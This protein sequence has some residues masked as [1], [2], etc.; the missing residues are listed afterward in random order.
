MTKPENKAPRESFVIVDNGEEPCL[1]YLNS[2]L[3]DIE[4]DCGAH[5]KSHFAVVRKSDFDDLQ[6]EIAKMLACPSCG[7]EYTYGV[8]TYDAKLQSQLDEKT[9]EVERL[10]CEPPACQTYEVECEALGRLCEQLEIDCS[11]C[12]D[13]QDLIRL[14]KGDFDNLRAELAEKTAEADRL[15][16]ALE[17]ENNKARERFLEAE[18]MR[19]RADVH[20]AE[21][22]EKVAEIAKLRAEL[23]EAKT[24]IKLLT[25]ACHSRANERDHN[26]DLAASFQAENKRLREAISKSICFHFCDCLCPLCEALNLK[27]EEPGER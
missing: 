25:S 1:A 9:A 18:K 4:A 13:K 14:I 23:D 5:F 7:E 2:S 19:D 11:C 20:R 10:K 27:Q 12:Y 3:A 8:G 16:E 15:R 24:E 6:A 22:T 17:V 26:Y 21:T